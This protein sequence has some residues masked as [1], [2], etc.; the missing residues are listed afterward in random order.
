MA[1]PDL[2]TMF[3]NGMGS[4]GAIQAGGMQADAEQQS[5][6]QQQMQAAQLQQLQQS[7]QQAQVMNPL[8]AQQ[9]Q[10]QIDAQNAQLPGLQG[11]SQQQQTQGQ[12]AQ[13]TAPQQIAEQLS[14]LSTKIGANGMEQMG[15]DAQKAVQAAQML[16][17]VPDM[18]K[19][20]ALKAILDQYGIKP[21][22]PMIAPILNGDPTKIVSALTTMGQGMAL[23]SQKYQQ[24]S[25][26]ES[27]RTKSASD[28]ESQRA[29]SDQ[30]V[31]GIHAS[32]AIQAA[33]IGAD[34]RQRAAEAAAK[35]RSQIANTKMS[36]DQKLAALTSIP[37]D[38]K[39]QDDF[40]QI[41]QLQ[42]QRLAERAAGAN[43]LAAQV[44][45]LPSAQQIAQQ[46]IQPQGQPAPVQ[47]Q[48]QVAP[49]IPQGWRQIGTSNGVPVFEDANGG[50]HIL[51]A[52]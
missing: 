3:N 15:Q 27:Q 9:A 33:Q 5:Q 11:I 47:Q 38:Q 36:T 13:A 49:T 45:G 39:S 40:H 18:N 1:L 21:D 41:D 7:N 46:G 17:N 28:I 25:A 48:Q 29:I 51:K 2:Q 30:K 50:R 20:A 37:D 4:L 26:L 16:G 24:D 35:V 32:A 31:A 22:N 10:G 43:P 44:M 8:Q 12:I 52:Q 23:A 42:K 34:S 6:Y 14:A 19:P